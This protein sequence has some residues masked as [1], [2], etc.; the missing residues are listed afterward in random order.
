M[1]DEGK[2]LKFNLTWTFVPDEDRRTSVQY[3]AGKTY[4]V[5]GQCARKALAAGVAE[6]ADPPQGSKVDARESKDPE[7]RELDEAYE[8]ASRL[9]APRADE[10]G[11][12]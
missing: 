7:F 4:R 1:A 9:G 12:D 3:L 2:W 10:S 8:F 5:R 11:R 6:V